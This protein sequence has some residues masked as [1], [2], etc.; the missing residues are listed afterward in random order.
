MRWEKYQHTDGVWC[1]IRLRAEYR[2]RELKPEMKP[3][4]GK[5]ALLVPLWL[6]GDGDRYPGEW[7]LADAEGENTLSSVGISWIASGDVKAI[8]LE[9]S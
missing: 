6:M 7:A 2:G 4:E 9:K 3:L 1:A 5:V 8:G